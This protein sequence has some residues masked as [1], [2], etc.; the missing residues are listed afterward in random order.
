[1]TWLA[2]AVTS[3]PPLVTWCFR[4]R[5]YYSRPLPSW[6]LAELNS[7]QAKV[8]G[9]DVERSQGAHLVLIGAGGLGSTAA[10][11]LSRKGIGHMTVLDDDRVELKNLTR[12]LFSKGDIGRNKAFALGKRLTHDGLFAL[13]MD[14]CAMR[15]Q[16]L[17]EA[18][19]SLL[20]G[21]DVWLALVDNDRTRH[22]ACV[23]A[24]KRKKPVICVALARDA[25]SLYCAIQEPG[26][27][28]LG[29][30][31]RNIAEPSG[32]YPCNL[33]GIN[34]IVMIA[35]GLA[36]YAVDTLLSGRDRCW[37]YR[38][39]RLDGS[40]P[41]RCEMVERNPSCRL[42][43]IQRSEGSDARGASDRIAEGAST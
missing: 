19:P 25:T 28:C 2:A 42:C 31:R 8:H 36:V 18:K 32:E 21:T 35:A 38:T 33:P 43:G 3:W 37:N 9:F 20:D 40:M 26:R 12:Q 30:V 39:L 23:E 15:F 13:R 5:K 7:S 24:L 1:M 22:D 17:L 14:A 41:E 10:H 29:C 4:R 6:E 11:M 27:A 34:D 16:E